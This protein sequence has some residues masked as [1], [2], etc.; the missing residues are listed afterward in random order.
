MRGGESG[1][2]SNR[3]ETPIASVFAPCFIRGS[4]RFGSLRIFDSSMHVQSFSR[5]NPHN[6]LSRDE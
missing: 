3:Y 5:T 4:N 2:K 1:H 6:V